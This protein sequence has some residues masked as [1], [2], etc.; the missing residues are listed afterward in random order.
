MGFLQILS[1][2]KLIKE[3][4]I[5]DVE[6]EA[7]KEGKSLEFVLIQRG[8]NP[9]QILEAKGDYFSVPV[10]VIDD[11]KIPYEI[12]KIIPESS[13]A[14]YKFVP[15][16]LEEGVLEVGVVD[17]N[18]IEARDA[19]QF[20]SSKERMPYKIFLISEMDFQNILNSYKGLRGEVSKA[21]GELESELKEDSL[22]LEEEKSANSKKEV[23]TKLI[24]D[25]PATKI[26]ATILKYAT[27]GNASDI[28]I[29]PLDESVKIRFRVDGQMQTSLVLPKNILN[30]VVAR[31]KVLSNMKLD[32]KRKPQDGR[33]AAHISGRKIDFRVSTFPT[34]YG[35]KVVMRILDSEKGVIKLQNLGLSRRNLDFI[36]NAIQRP[37][38]M[39]LISG[40]TG[41]G[42]TT[43]L[44]S[45]INELDKE[46]KNI[47]SLE[48]PVE[49]NIPGM[50][51]SQI[52]PEIGYTF[53]TGLR[54]TLRQDP[55]IIMVGEIRDKET[56]GLAVQAAL[57]GHLVLSTIHTNNA[58]GV[59]PRL[60][61]MGIDP[62]LIAPTLILAMAQR[63]VRT[64]CPET[65]K[66]RPV[67][68]SLKAMID[69]Q[70]SDL[71]EVYRKEIGDI[72]SVYER[73][74]T[75]ECPSGTKGRTAV[76]E[77]LKMT[78]GLERTILQNP[79][80]QEIV[81]EARKQGML[82]MLEDAIIK[83]SQKLVPFEEVNTLRAGAD[84]I[85]L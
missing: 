23:R 37:Y 67:E 70:F 83:S 79:T 42:K 54:T 66:E 25:A 41:S 43:T 4:E 10:R 55:D 82:S 39:V 28:H 52:R 11:Q 36:K 26:V 46:S 44:Y 40:P 85:I 12:L 68:G 73:E 34:Y 13:A 63:L 60:V 5:A 47:L 57:T 50:N 27:E 45:M 15:I 81:K 31:I 29:E 30:P 80:E 78:R 75:P 19:L 21:L 2:K 16:G 9:A 53:A 51:Q 84:D 14:H 17:P 64:L 20:I 65:G 61:D 22:S 6:K 35:E 69:K 18:N 1:Q 71:P 48:D 56:A 77:V 58:I 49:Y 38:G 62:Y 33:F 7:V 76:M 72:K 8:I 32:E 74:E 59:I 24:E 3:T